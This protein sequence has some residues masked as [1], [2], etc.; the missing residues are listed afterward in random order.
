MDGPCWALVAFGGPAMFR[1]IPIPEDYIP[2]ALTRGWTVLG[3][4]RDVLADLLLDHNLQSNPVR[5]PDV[6]RENQ[7]AE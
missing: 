5:R 4:D 1:V 3:R 7:G 2:D 6:G